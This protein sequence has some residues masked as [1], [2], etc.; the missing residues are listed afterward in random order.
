MSRFEKQPLKKGLVVSRQEV[1][2]E[3]LDERSGTNFFV[4]RFIF[5]QKEGFSRA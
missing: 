4:K 3:G 5:S 2:F 1:S